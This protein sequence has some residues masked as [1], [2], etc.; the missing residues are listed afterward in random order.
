MM[1]LSGKLGVLAGGGPLPIRIVEACRDQGRPVYAVVFKGQGDPADFAHIG[2]SEIRI[3][4]GGAAIK[5][6]RA[7]GCET[8]V[9][10]GTIRRPTLQQIRPDWWG[11]KFFAKTRADKLGDDGLLSALIRALED[12]G[13]TV[14]GADDILPDMLMPRGVVG[15]MAPEDTDAADIAAALQASKDLGARDAGQAAVARGGAVVAEEGPDG[16]D[17]MLGRLAAAANKGGIL[18]K[19]LKPGQER[20]ADLP[21][22]GSETL[23]NAAAA[24]LT[25]VVVEAG[26]AFLMDRDEAARTADELGLFLIGVDP[27]GAW[28]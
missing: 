19:T 26:N 16:T 3:G 14:C 10:A 4:A 5:R 25:G 28:S 9:M 7:E 18:A 2:H 11:I 8:L 24:G 6:L 20:R 23:K 12:E 21:M 17:A 15:S 13:F 1:P 22:L 27:E